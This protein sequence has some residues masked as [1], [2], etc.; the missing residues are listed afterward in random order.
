MLRDSEDRLELHYDYQSTATYSVRGNRMPVVSGSAVGNISQYNIKGKWQVGNRKVLRSELNYL[1][2]FWRARRGGLQRFR[3][4]DWGDFATTWNGVHDQGL[5]GTGTG[6]GVLKQFQLI[7]RYQPG[8]DSQDRVITKP[9]AGTVNVYVNGAMQA[10]GWA[11]NTSTGIVTFTLPPANGA[12]LRASFEFD[13]LVRFTG[14]FGRTFNFYHVPDDDAV[15][16]LPGLTV[17][18]V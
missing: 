3:L 12:V 14:D 16:T 8:G 5:L 6:N 15:Y 2:A 1:Q 10:S 13:V 4:K 7:K 11:V 18:E 17:E 9:V